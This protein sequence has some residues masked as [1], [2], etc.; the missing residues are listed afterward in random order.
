MP[1]DFAQALADEALAGLSPDKARTVAGRIDAALD[2]PDLSDRDRGVLLGARAVA[3]QH[4]QPTSEVRNILLQAIPLLEEAGEI[5]RATSA[6]TA[7]ASVNLMLGELREC[8]DHAVRALTAASSDQLET[9]P[10]GVSGNLGVLFNEF[11]A[12]DL[13][14]DL[15]KA[16]FESCPEDGPFLVAGYSFAR[17]IVDAAWAAEPDSEAFTRIDIAAQT[18][19][20]LMAH[21][22]N[23]DSPVGPMGILV[24]QIILTEVELLRCNLEQAAEHAC[25]ALKLSDGAQSILSGSAHLAAAMVAR[26]QGRPADALDHLNAAEAPFEHEPNRLDRL[27]A[28]RAASHAALGN[29]EAA[30]HEAMLRSESTSQRNSQMMD[31]VIGQ[32]RARAHAEHSRIS[33][34][35]HM[36]R[37]ALTGVGSRGWFDSCLEERR[38]QAGQT[39]IV[40]LDID[41]FKA[42]NDSYSHQVGDDVLRRIGELLIAACQ[43]DDVVAR[44][45]GEEFVVLPASGELDDAHDLAE[46]IRL[47]IEAEPWSQYGDALAVTTSIGVASGDSP[48]SLGILRAADQALYAAKAAGRNQVAVEPV[49]TRA[50][51]RTT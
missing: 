6:L 18:A 30:Y 32:I 2:R 51:D 9:M 19:N 36:R 31:A 39:A 38:L 16:A 42:V 11:C 35:E 14:F 50:T 27:R 26:R 34:T 28:E 43:D 5:G 44:Y 1:S 33:L 37:D 15:C 10:T 40:L 20:R 47:A 41:H 17:T 22:P 49:R 48:R 13:S 23:R 4:F 3:G 24:G 29:F 25:C 8:M 7:L 45:G 46:R 12:F 21:R